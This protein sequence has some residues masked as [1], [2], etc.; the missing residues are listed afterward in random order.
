MS[1]PR[2]NHGLF[3]MNS[4]SHPRLAAVRA[5]GAWSSG[6]AFRNRS[7]GSQAA[8]SATGAPTADLE[9]STVI[10]KGNRAS[11]DPQRFEMLANEGLGSGSIFPATGR[12]L[13]Y[14]RAVLT[15]ARHLKSGSDQRPIA[16]IGGRGLVVP[17]KKERHPALNEAAP[18]TAPIAPGGRRCAQEQ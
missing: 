10:T 5:G 4:P 18:G 7:R 16:G 8:D 14:S 6:A 3:K 1:I 11:N 17:G 15:L 12:H 2:P 13:V 9:P